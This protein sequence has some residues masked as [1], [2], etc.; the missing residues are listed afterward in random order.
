MAAV[1]FQATTLATPPAGTAVAVRVIAGEDHQLT[2]FEFDDGAAGATLVSAANPLPVNTELTTKDLDTGGGT[3]TQAVV[4]LL[5]AASGGAT[6]VSAAAGL[7][8]NVV[9]GSAANAAAGATAAAVPASADYQGINVAGT[10]R[11]VTGASRGGEFA[12]SI[13]I[14]DAAGAQITSFGGT[15]GVVTGYHRIA[16]ADTNAVNIAA[17]STKLRAVRAY[18]H[19]DYPISF[20][21]HNT[22]GAPT[23]GVSVV[24]KY[25]VQAGQSRDVQITG[26]GLLFGT[27]LALTAVKQV[28][29]TGLADADATA[30]AAGDFS[31]EVEY[32]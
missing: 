25:T 6:L 15:A 8:V 23:A 17:V 2:L 5:F 4:G 10:L 16:T 20:C 21:F 14:V 1:T 29:G 11:G 18:V 12:Q 9:A 3:D 28:V 24:R 13:Q 22:A 30:C 31:L 19:A 32:E 26:G 27:G 7:P